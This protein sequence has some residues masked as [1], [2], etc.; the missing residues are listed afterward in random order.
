MIGV[1]A[2]FQTDGVTAI[3]TDGQRSPGDWAQIAAGKIV[4]VADTA[5]QP[6]RDQAHAFKSRV[7]RVI[8]NYIEMA[9]QEERAVMA[10]KLARND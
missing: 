6:I 7:Q 2:A 4:S 9:L 8:E 5:P 10:A 3:A 1:S